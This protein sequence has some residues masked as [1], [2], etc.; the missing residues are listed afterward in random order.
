VKDD[1]R[2]FGQARCDFG[3]LTGLVPQLEIEVDAAERVDPDL[4]HL[5][6]LRQ[7]AP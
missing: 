3:L 1:T 5:I 7:R 4:A 6:N 2:A